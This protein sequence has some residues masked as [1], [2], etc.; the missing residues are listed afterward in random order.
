MYYNNEA[1]PEA[2]VR[3]DQELRDVFK[4]LTADWK[5]LDRLYQKEAS[6]KKV[7]VCVL[8]LLS[9]LYV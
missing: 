6:K 2:K 3:K 5:E 8:A 7:S 9:L 4:A 1:A